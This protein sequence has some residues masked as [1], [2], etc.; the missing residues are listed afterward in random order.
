MHLCKLRDRLPKLQ[1]RLESS[2][3]LQSSS[4]GFLRPFAGACSTAPSGT[5]QAEQSDGSECQS[6]KALKVAPATSA[7]IAAYIS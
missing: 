4:L 6:R 1:D 3:L 2:E 5:R 7:S